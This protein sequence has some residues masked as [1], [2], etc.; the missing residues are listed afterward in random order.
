[1]VTVTFSHQGA[2]ETSMVSDPVVAAAAIDPA[3]MEAALAAMT[4]AAVLS[5][6][7]SFAH[8]GCP[9]SKLL[10]AIPPLRRLD[11]RRPPASLNARQGFGFRKLFLKKVRVGSVACR[12]GGRSLPHRLA[13][14]AI[15]LKRR[16]GF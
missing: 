7:H 14:C 12:I 10:G 5:T 16:S 11:C 9:R 15:R 3:A 2:L 6:S 13:P 4:R 1:M 8:L